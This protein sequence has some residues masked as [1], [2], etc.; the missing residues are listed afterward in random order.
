MGVWI[1]QHSAVVD[2]RV[3]IVP[4]AVFCWHLV[5]GDAGRR[6]LSADHDIAVIFV[7]V[8]S[9][10]HNVSVE[11]RTPVVGNSADNRAANS[12]NNRTNR[13]ADDCAADCAAYGTGRCI[14]L[15]I[16]RERS[17]QRRNDGA[18]P[19]QG[20]SSLL[21]PCVMTNAR[22]LR[23]AHPRTPTRAGCVCSETHIPPGWQVDTKRADWL[24]IYQKTLQRL[25]GNANMQSAFPPGSS[26]SP[27]ADQIRSFV[28]YGPRPP[29]RPVS[30][31]SQRRD[32]GTHRVS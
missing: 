30:F 22:M 32:R 2:Y 7:G 14:V 1:H 4:Y 23:A 27:G 24:L 6:Q 20:G 21:S 17:R 29:T 25:F 18:L 11:L 26:P 16:C 31:R 13:S 8:P 10:L 3:S 15:S 12:A 9:F 28:A 5:I 19:S